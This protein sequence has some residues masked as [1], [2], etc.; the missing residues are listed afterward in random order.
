MKRRA[1]KHEVALSEDQRN[2]LYQLISSGQAPARK[3]AHARILLKIDRN[4][5]GC[6]WS[7]EQVLAS[8]LVELEYTE[9]VSYET[10]R[11]VLKKMN[12]TRG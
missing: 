6:E 5:P 8:R 10:V 2:T 4:T 3:L 11:R 12:S 7:D 1:H 9:Q